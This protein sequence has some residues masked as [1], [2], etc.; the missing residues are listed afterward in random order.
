[1]KQQDD[2]YYTDNGYHPDRIFLVD[3]YMDEIE[4]RGNP[5]PENFDEP[6]EYTEYIK[7][8]YVRNLVKD[9][10]ENRSTF[11]PF[12]YLLEALEK[13]LFTP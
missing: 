12:Q 9:I 5:N 13:H 1:M 2:G 4:W 8:S 11:M 10:K 3:G 7:A 6:P